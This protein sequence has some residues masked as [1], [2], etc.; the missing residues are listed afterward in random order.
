MDILCNIVQCTRPPL[1]DVLMDSVFP[2]VVNTILASDD[3]SVLQVYMLKEQFDVTCH[4]TGPL[5][6]DW[7]I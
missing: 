6:C 5:I 1:S 3:N 4:S 2:V 7:I